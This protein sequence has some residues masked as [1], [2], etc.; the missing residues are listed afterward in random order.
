MSS[1]QST[2]PR[3]PDRQLLCVVAACR[4]DGARHDRRRRHVVGRRRAAGGPGRVRRRSRADASLPYTAAMLGFAVGGVLM[5]RLA[6][7]FGIMPP[8]AHRRAHARARATCSPRRRPASWQFALAQGAAHRHARQFRD[9]RA[10]DRRHLALVHDAAAAS[11]SRSSRRA[12]ISRARS[13]RRS[14]ST[15]STTAGWRQTHV[16]VGVFCVA[17]HAAA[18]P[19]AA[20]ARRRRTTA[21]PPMSAP[22][23]ARRARLS[24]ATLQGLL[25]DRRPCLLRRD[26]DAAGAHRRLLRR[27]RLRRRRA[28]P[29]C[30]R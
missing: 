6:D 15:S 24:P 18:G 29:R 30:C 25:V 28:A 3:G 7:R 22:R 8:G 20:P 10:A 2:V 14:C 4:L 23:P 5:G 17:H 27:P 19:G 9:L 21:R 26:V 16:G 11:R 12:T 13:G 1:A